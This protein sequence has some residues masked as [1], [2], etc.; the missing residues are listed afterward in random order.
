MS[1]SKLAQLEQE[2]K[3][4]KLLLKNTPAPRVSYADIEDVSD[5]YQERLE[6]NWWADD[7]RTIIAEIEQEIEKVRQF[8]DP[9]SLE[10]YDLWKALPEDDNQGYW[11]IKNGH[12]AHTWDFEESIGE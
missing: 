7:Q 3:D 2:L 9:E 4:A 6:Y 12:T 11:Y 5:A 8:I 1:I 10:A